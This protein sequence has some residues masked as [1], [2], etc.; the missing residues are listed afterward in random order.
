MNIGNS[1]QVTL[2]YL[3]KIIRLHYPLKFKE[4]YL[5]KNLSDVDQTKTNTTLFTKLVGKL[6]F[7][8]FKTEYIEFIS[9]YKE[10]FFR[11]K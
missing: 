1:K 3:V 10:I 4:I 7:S 2:K 11:K 9:W 5:K 8:D 6:N